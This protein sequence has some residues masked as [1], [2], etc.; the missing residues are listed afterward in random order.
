MCGGG[1]G[2]MPMFHFNTE[3]GAS[4]ADTEGVQLADRDEAKTQAVRACADWMR[5]AG[6]EFWEDGSFTLTVVNDQGLTLFQI[7]V[8]GVQAPAVS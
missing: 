2:A 8:V 6:G 5:D 4:H 7:F 1:Y 3:N